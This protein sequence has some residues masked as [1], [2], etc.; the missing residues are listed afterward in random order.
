MTLA[1]LKVLQ[2]IV[3]AGSV[4]AAAQRLNK[5]QP[6]LSSAIS[7]LEEELG[8]TLFDRNSYRL[9]LSEPGRMLYK[10]IRN[11]LE[12]VDSIQSSAE[13]LARGHEARIVVSLEVLTPVS[14][15]SRL[16]AEITK[17]FPATQILFRADVLGGALEKLRNETVN[18]A[19]GPMIGAIDGVEKQRVTTVELTAVGETSIFQ[20]IQLKQ[21]EQFPQIA[22]LD[23]AD[24]ASGKSYAMA[25]GPR[26]I[27]VPDYLAKKQFLLDG[28]G[29]GFMPVHLVQRELEEGWLTRLDCVP[30]NRR[31]I[32]LYAFRLAGVTSG[33]VATLMWEGISAY[34][35]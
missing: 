21:L 34:F 3:E 8:V 9:V 30:K 13:L 31:F 29:W 5:T 1:Q 20:G 12:Q 33:P 23:T 26:K 4:A 17:D 19:V 27:Y 7:R 32:E 10:G 15:V 35:E 25:G 16:A 11:V 22:M 18:I 6:A 28:A 14:C 24:G 2:A